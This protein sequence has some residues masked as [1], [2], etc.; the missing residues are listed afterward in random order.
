MKMNEY[1]DKSIAILDSYSESDVK[2][3]LKTFI[4]YTA[5]RKR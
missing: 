5:N 3:S 4:G 1:L 2:E